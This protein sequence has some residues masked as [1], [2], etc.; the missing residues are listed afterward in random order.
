MNDLL[1]N[2]PFF[3]DPAAP[4]LIVSYLQF[5]ADLGRSLAKKPLPELTLDPPKGRVNDEEELTLDPFEGRM[6]GAYSLIANLFAAIVE[7]RDFVLDEHAGSQR[8]ALLTRL[9]QSQRGGMTVRSSLSTAWNT[10]DGEALPNRILSS[11]SRITLYTS[12]TTGTPKPITQ[13]LTNLTRAVQI[14]PKHENDVWGLTYQPTKIAALQVLLQAV[15]NNNTIVNLSGLPAADA[16][17]AI[18]RYRI[19]HLSATPTYYRLLAANLEPFSDIKAVT[20]GGEVCDASL[21]K[22][23][24]QLFPN[25]RFR[26]VYASSELGTLLH[27]SDDCFVVPDSLR[28]AVRVQEGR[29]WIHK[30]HVAV[31]LQAQCENEFWDSGD[32]VELLQENPLRFRITGRRTDWINVGGVKINPHDVEHAL[33]QIPGIL[34]ARVFGVANSVTGQ[35]VAAEITLASTRDA[36]LGEP[37]NVAVIRAHLHGK[38]PHHAIPRIIHFREGL[39]VSTS[40]KKERMN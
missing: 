35:L 26:N 17:H 30:D 18:R 5:L 13:S 39:A 23:L 2:R 6:K 10:Y 33:N 27:S 11:P 21:R 22:R 28:H 9:N 20:V 4:D 14:S 3:I 16:R 36:A 37:M 32:E 19:T 31:N 24:E 12:G 1:G 7:G 38:L 40:G 34:D 25:A 8:G 29:L 15:C